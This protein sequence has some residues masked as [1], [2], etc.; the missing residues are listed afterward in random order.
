MPLSRQPFTW[1]SCISEAGVG[2]WG[3][4][5]SGKTSHPHPALHASWVQ[6]PPAPSGPPCLVLGQGQQGGDHH[7]D[8]VAVQG[9]QLEGQ[10]LAAACG[11]LERSEVASEPE[12]AL[13]R[14]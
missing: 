11:V 13:P 7:G 4:C 14:E 1:G 8:L 2:S 6:H 5:W 10:A 3:C 12:R 9:R